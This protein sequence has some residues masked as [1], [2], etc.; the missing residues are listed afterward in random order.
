MWGNDFR[1]ANLDRWEDEGKIEYIYKLFKTEIPRLITSLEG[2]FC[3]Y[4][5]KFM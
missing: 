1:L 3:C 5:L 4:I 2:G